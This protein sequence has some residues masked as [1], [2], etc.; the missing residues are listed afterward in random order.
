MAKRDTPP[1]VSLKVNAPL[2]LFCQDFFFLFSVYNSQENS[3]ASQEGYARVYV[4][5][6]LYLYI[7]VCKCACVCDVGWMA[8]WKGP[9]ELACTCII[10][11]GSDF[12]PTLSCRRPG[13]SF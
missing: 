13:I 12:F 8:A 11:T 10:F 5:V 9:L 6:L 4:C 7:Y 3:V 2:F 1:L